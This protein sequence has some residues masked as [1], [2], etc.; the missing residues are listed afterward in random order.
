MFDEV[1]GRIAGRFARPETRCTAAELLV[2]L[3]A[4]IERKNGW[5]L[6]MAALAILVATT[7]TQ[8]APPPGLAPLTVPET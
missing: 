8:A 5:W 1:A 2:G 7:A 4:S 6:A 3:L